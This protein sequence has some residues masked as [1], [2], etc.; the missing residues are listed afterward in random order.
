MLRTSQ[1]ILRAD[2]AL[3]LVETGWIW[4]LP[5]ADFF[6]QILFS[7]GPPSLAGRG[8]ARPAV[9]VCYLFPDD[10]IDLLFK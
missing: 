4:P 2:L 1:R 6:L 8:I 9:L 3:R 5:G 7:G 10:S